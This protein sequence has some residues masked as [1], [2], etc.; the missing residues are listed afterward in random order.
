[1]QNKIGPNSQLLRIRLRIWRA[2]WCMVFKKK[3]FC[4]DLINL[5]FQIEAKRQ[6]VV[7]FQPS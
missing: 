5:L 2:S 4:Y 6:A 3:G 7:N 1:M